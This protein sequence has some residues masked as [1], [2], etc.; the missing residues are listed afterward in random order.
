LKTLKQKETFCILGV[1]N[2]DLYPRDEWNF[3]FGLASLGD[4]CGVF[5]FCRYNPEFTGEKFDKLLWI[6]RACHVMAHETVHMFGM[7][8]CIYYECLMNGTMSAEESARRRN[9][10]LCPVC[11]KKLKANIKFDTKLR[12]ENLLQAATVLGF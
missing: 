7:K 6:R 5:S 4:A 8:H 3:V 12:F 10:T 2:R 9:N 1:T 11:L